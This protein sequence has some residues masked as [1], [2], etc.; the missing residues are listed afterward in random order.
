LTEFGGKLAFTADDRIHGEEL[1]TSD[2]TEAGTTL[3]DLYPGSFGSDVSQI[4]NIDGALFFGAYVPGSRRSLVKSDGTPAGTVIGKGAAPPTLEHMVVLNGD[5]Y[6]VGVTDQGERHLWKGDGSSVSITRVLEPDDYASHPGAL[7]VANGRLYFVAEMANEESGL[8]ESNGTET[9]T[10]LLGE[11]PDDL[12]DVQV[13]ANINGIVIAGARYLNSLERELWAFEP[14]GASR[15]LGNRSSSF[16]LNG[17]AILDDEMIFAAADSR[18][19]ELWTSDGTYAGT[20]LVKDLNAAITDES[21]YPEEFVTVGTT[22]FFIAN[23]GVH[24]SQLWKT[25]GTEAG[26]MLVKDFNPGESDFAAIQTLGST[27]MLLVF[28]EMDG[29]SD[30][31]GVALWKSDGTEAGTALVRDFGNQLAP[32]HRGAV[33]SGGSLFFALGNDL[34]KSDGTEAGTVLV[35]HTSDRFGAQPR[36]LTDVNRTLYFTTRLDSGIALWKSDGTEA[37]TAI[38]TQLAPFSNAWE[39]DY[40]WNVDG[41]LFFSRADGTRL[42]LWTSNGTES[43][44]LPL[45]TL[46]TS[47]RFLD[48]IASLGGKLIFSAGDGNEA[49]LYSSDGTVQGTFLLRAGGVR[50]HN[51]AVLNGHVYFSVYDSALGSELWKSDG[52]AAGT[53]IVKDIEPNPT[54]DANP[55]HLVSANGRLYFLGDDDTLWTSDGTDEGTFVL[56]DRVEAEYL[57]VAPSHIFF[58]NRISDLGT[59]LWALP[60]PSTVVGRN[61]FYNNS[62]FDQLTPEISQLDDQAIATDKTAFIAES[63]KATVANVS[64]YS[65]GINALMVDIAGAKEGMSAADFTFR[66]GT[67]DSLETWTPAPAPLSLSVRAG[68]GVDGSDRVVLIWADGAIKD[69]WL[70][71]IVEGNDVAGG[72]NS[73]TGLATSDV[74]Y[75]GN[76]VADSGSGTG[77]AS[78]ETNSTDAIQVYA[79]SGAN[80]PITD[81]CDYNRDGKVDSTDAL[82]AFASGGSLIRLDLGNGE[83]PA[84]PMNAVAEP[85]NGVA[86]ASGV[87]FALA[88]EEASSASVEPATH[89]GVSVDKPVASPLEN[90][91][92]ELIVSA[93]LVTSYVENAEH[94]LVELADELLELLV[95]R[96]RVR[97]WAGACL[98]S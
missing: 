83:A 17:F 50:Q 80:R 39:D 67:N 44:T 64:S 25:D 41:R 93:G 75:F 61:L 62:A 47:S 3:L 82:I 2:G 43:G 5:V 28:Y 87:A 79:R 32:D 37:G 21:S 22:T 53:S 73:T 26:T 95:G 49:G 74:F 57:W 11:V 12:R 71:V 14:G 23:D 91:G 38:V 13:L 9:G 52:T 97:S 36:G 54:G 30:D 60:L 81:S 76:K 15:L 69:A 65:R 59:E 78:F 19:L 98:T 70:Q 35:K 6:F 92:R 88:I 18:G 20:R 51:M 8:W 63:G 33:S 84:L 72:F 34:W 68:A 85:L 90:P 46:R 96:D 94:P 66:V 10:Q 58:A 7:S 86:D 27:L 48:N 77:A 4:C 29:E 55:Q 24:G 89:V 31:R 16:G 42:T 40:L 56:S 45:V 1:W